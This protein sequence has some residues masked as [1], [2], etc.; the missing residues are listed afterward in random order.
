MLKLTGALWHWQCASPQVWRSNHK[1][2]SDVQESTGTSEKATLSL[3]AVAVLQ[4]C[5]LRECHHTCYLVASLQFRA[6][7]R[8]CASWNRMLL[9]MRLQRAPVY[10]VCLSNS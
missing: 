7:A 10:T 3:H 5:I 8:V 4:S 9:V 6:K 2:T 1:G